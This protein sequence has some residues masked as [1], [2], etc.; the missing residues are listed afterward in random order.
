MC[1][2]ST[3]TPTDKVVYS[4]LL[5]GSMKCYFGFKTELCC[6]LPE[7]TL[8]GDEKDW[9][10]IERRAERLCEF[11]NAEGHM[12]KWYKMLRPI[13]KNFTESVKGNPDIEWWSRV[14]NKVG[15]GS[16]PRYLSGWIT[17]FCVFN[18][19]LKWVGEN[20]VSEYVSKGF[21]S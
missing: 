14:C 20:S 4:V 18:D 10:E 21:V 12:K 5:M 11:D 3:T 7:V 16:G 17:A 9:S 15:N 13:L 6:G 2:F 8:Q 1:N 19:R